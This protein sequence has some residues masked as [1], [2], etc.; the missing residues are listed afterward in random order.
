MQSV[1]AMDKSRVWQVGPACVSDREGHA[2][3]RS[4]NSVIQFLTPAG[5]DERMST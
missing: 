5:I 3:A 2:V 1:Q 4:C